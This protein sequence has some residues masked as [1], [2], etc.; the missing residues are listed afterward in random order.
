MTCLLKVNDGY[1]RSIFATPV[2]LVGKQQE[3]T[4]N[5]KGAVSLTS[6]LQEQFTPFISAT[7]SYGKKRFTIRKLA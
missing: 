5:D 6:I 7:L 3:R 2:S 1:L 4:Y